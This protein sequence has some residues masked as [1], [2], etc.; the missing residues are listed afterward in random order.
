MS[1]SSSRSKDTDATRMLKLVCALLSRP[2]SEPFREPLDWKALGLHDY[3]KIVKK[4]MDLGTVKTKL[5]KGVYSGIEAVATDIR[6]VWTNCIAYNQDGSEFYHLADTFAKKFEE[7]YATIRNRKEE[8]T[9]RVPLLDE[10]IQLSYDIF[11]LS[12]VD[13]GRALTMIEEKCTMALSKRRSEDEVMI[14]IDFIPPQLFHEVSRFIKGCL[15]KDK[16]TS[17]S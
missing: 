8:D 16:K 13:L 11:K 15:T 1:A 5:E 3:P 17:G 9:G 12:D 2:E 4:P 6:L 14:N 10:R 7:A